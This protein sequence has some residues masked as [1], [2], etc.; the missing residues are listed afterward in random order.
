[1]FDLTREQIKKAEDF[2]I[3]HPC[4][5]EKDEF[6]GWKV[7]AIGGRISFH[8]TPTSLGMIMTV[9]CMC[10]DERDLTEYDDW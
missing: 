8:F 1:M 10:G 9:S 7:G 6:G 3:N 2:R 5:I 4:T